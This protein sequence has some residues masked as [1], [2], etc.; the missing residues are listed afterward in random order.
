MPRKPNKPGQPKTS[1]LSF[2]TTKEIRENLEHVAAASGRSLV[3]ELEERLVRSFE[4]DRASIEL[5]LLPLMARIYFLSLA[6]AKREPGWEFELDDPA[7]V[8]AITMA[9][10]LI[11][12]ACAK[13][14]TKDQIID[15]WQRVKILK[16]KRG[17]APYRLAVEAINILS[18]GKVITLPEIVEGISEA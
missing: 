7:V 16:K 12:Q 10:S 6:A 13:P 2:R 5:D 9:L 3:H 4:D 17:K 8:E 15:Y 11:V 18:V 14:L 1:P